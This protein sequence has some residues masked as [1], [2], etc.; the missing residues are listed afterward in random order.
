MNKDLKFNHLLNKGEEIP[1]NC[2]L[3][4]WGFGSVAGVLFSASK[5]WSLVYYQPLK[6]FNLS[7]FLGFS[8]YFL[9]YNLLT[10]CTFQACHSTFWGWGIG[11]GGE[12]LTTKMGPVDVFF[13]EFSFSKHFPLWICSESSETVDG[14]LKSGINSP[15]KGCMNYETLEIM[16]FQL[17]TSTGELIPDFRDPSTER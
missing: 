17:P 8:P 13:W 11:F 4:F 3:Y 5:T 16:G 7:A 14:S 15:P 10:K 9:V 12:S 1:R 2:N 6:A